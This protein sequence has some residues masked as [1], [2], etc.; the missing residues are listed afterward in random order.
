MLWEVLGGT[1]CEKE[2]L[3]RIRERLE[4]LSPSAPPH[5]ALLP[6]YASAWDLFYTSASTLPHKILLLHPKLLLYLAVG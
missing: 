3:R 5:A 1:G 4:A 6:I 2:G